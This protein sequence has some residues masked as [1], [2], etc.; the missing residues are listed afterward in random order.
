MQKR[1]VGVIKGAVFSLILTIMLAVVLAVIMYFCDV[2]EIMT[3]I[4]VFLIGAVS[5]AAGAF[6]V[7]KAAG[8][9][10]LVTGGSVGALYYV[11]LIMVS[12][13]IKK[14]LSIETHMVIMLAMT[15]FS[16]MLG[17]ILAMPR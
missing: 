15:V 2:S 12:A 16:G 11:V 3:E 13:I 5:C 6:C 8:N 10:G 7:A 1:A 14:E 17:G 9:K 4:C